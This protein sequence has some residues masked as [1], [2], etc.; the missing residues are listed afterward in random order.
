MIEY[1]DIAL[2]DLVLYSEQPR[3]TLSKTTSHSRFFT[4]VHGHFRLS[5][6]G[7]LFTENNRKQLYQIDFS[8]MVVHSRSQSFVVDH[9]RSLLFKVVC[10]CSRSFNSIEKQKYGKQLLLHNLCSRFWMFEIIC[11]RPLSF[12]V[13]TER[14]SFYR[15]QPWV[16]ISSILSDISFT[17]F[18]A[19]SWSFVVDHGRSWMFTVVCSRSWSFHSIKKQ[20]SCEQLHD[21]VFTWSVTLVCSQS[22]S[23]TVVHGG[24][25]SF[26]VVHGHFTV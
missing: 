8:F 9:G 22:R 4:V 21:H 5:P 3:A 11:G 7:G 23:F 15:E 25:P 13:V 16:T 19:C 26:V 24:S 20:K 2:S 14:K 6:K 12:R 18:R 10:S 1:I 17:V